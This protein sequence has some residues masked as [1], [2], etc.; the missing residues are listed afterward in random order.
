MFFSWRKATGV[1]TG[2]VQSQVGAL[3][4]LLGLGIR[5]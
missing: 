5:V 4:V 1:V 3:D 2:D